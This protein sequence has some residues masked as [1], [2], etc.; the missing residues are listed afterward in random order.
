[1]NQK[2]QK[3][4]IYVHFSAYIYVCVCIHTLGEYSTPRYG[5]CSWLELEQYIHMFI[6][7]KSLK[8]W[9][10]IRRFSAYIFTNSCSYEPKFLS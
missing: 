2:S 4:N 6:R 7:T 8:R 9:S 1:M 5:G 3:M 10:H